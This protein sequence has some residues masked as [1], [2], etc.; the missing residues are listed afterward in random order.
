MKRWEEAEAGTRVEGA[1]VSRREE[2][3]KGSSRKGRQGIERQGRGRVNGGKRK[4]RRTG[5][6][7]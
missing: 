5:G 1:I 2:E 6:R 3:T 7:W 4:E